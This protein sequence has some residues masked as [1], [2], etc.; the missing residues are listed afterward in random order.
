MK[1]KNLDTVKKKSIPLYNLLKKINIETYSFCGFE[2]KK[3]DVDIYIDKESKSYIS[4]RLNKEYEAQ[5]LVDEIL[6]G[7]YDEVI[8]IGLGNIIMWETLL[9]RVNK[10]VKLHIVE[11]NEVM[12][13][14][15][16]NSSVKGID[17]SKLNSLSIIDDKFNFTSLYSIVMEKTNMN[18]K[19]FVLPQYKRIFKDEIQ[20]FYDDFKKV[21]ENKRKSIHTNR[22]YQK[23]WIF[24]SILNFK[25]V[26][27][28]PRFLDLQEV[29]FDNSVAIL[30]GAGPSLSRDIE[31]IKELSEK[32]RCYIFA[33]GSAY[34]ALAKHN[35]KMDMIFSY[36]PTELNADV[37][38]EYYEKEIDAPICFG[39][40]IGFEAI[41]KV[42]YKKAFHLLTSQD[43]FSMYLLEG[44]ESE[45]V[46][47]APSIVVIAVQALIKVGFSKII[48]SGQNL[49]YLNEQNYADGIVYKRLEGTS[50]KSELE[51]KDVFDNNVATTAGYK[52][53]LRILEDYIAMHKQ[54]DFINTTYGGAAIKGAPY[55]ALSD[56]DMDMFDQKV[57]LLEMGADD[58]YNVSNA[59]E[60]FEHLLKERDEFMKLLSDG[61]KL[62]Y[63]VKEGLDKK[64]FKDLSLLVALEKNYNMMTKN[65]YFKVLMSKMERSYINIFESGVVEIN[66]QENILK[67][68]ELVYNKMG[69]LYS[70][71][72]KDDVD[73]INLFKYINQ[74]IVWE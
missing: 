11:F 58:Y 64:R 16:D 6:S 72:K 38:S 8:V 69:T 33:I 68:Y 25:H 29:D 14:M 27:S 61:F 71:F 67:K 24:N 41:K 12:D 46:L 44:K 65:I 73:V 55:K 43:Y 74:Y 17:F 10:E 40:S 45:I 59:K 56:I 9:R 28:T 22:G 1:Y 35:I 5:L 47:D 53:T 37:L 23:R 66:R 52:M 34:R 21:I 54:V 57:D 60:R 3:K 36:D 63:D 32:K 50:Y 20:K 26:I 19:V 15:L 42:D 30:V 18:F 31:L 49:A 70:L 51:I 7:D 62:I 2:K 4:S 13:I 48:F 39:S